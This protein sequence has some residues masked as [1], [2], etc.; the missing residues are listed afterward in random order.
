M[1]PS[2][3]MLTS[4]IS[5]PRQ[6]ASG[7]S[8]PQS[9]WRRVVR[10]VPG[11]CAPRP[12][13]RQEGI[14]RRAADGLVRVGAVEDDAALR[15]SAQES[16]EDQLARILAESEETERAEKRRRLEAQA[17]QESEEDQLAR[18]LAESAATAEAE[19]RARAE[20][21]RRADDER[22]P[23]TTA[24]FVALWRATE[25]GTGVAMTDIEAGT[26]VRT[27]N[28]AGSVS[29]A[30]QDKAQYGR[31]FFGATRTV[32]E[33]TNLKASEVF[34]D[35][36]CG[37]GNATMQMA[38]TVGCEARGIE[39]MPDR[40]IVGHEHMW[41]ALQH[42]IGERDG[43]PP[44]VGEVVLRQADL[45]DPA[46]AEFLSSAD[47]AF[48]NNYN[49]IFGARSCKHGERS[50]DEHVARVFACMKP[51]SRMVTFHPL[52]LG[53]DAE[54]VNEVRRDRGL[55]P[56][57]DASFFTKAQSTLAP[58]PTA[59]APRGEDVVSWSDGP[60]KAY[61]YTRTAQSLEKACFLCTNRK[62]VGKD[63][64]TAFVNEESLDLVTECIFCGESRRPAERD[65]GESR[66]G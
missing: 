18:I 39:L 32:A 6:A 59:W 29:G 2:R 40:H 35:I 50:L 15:Q 3:A 8:R 65:R 37:V 4:A 36:G 24:E 38:C 54:K 45:A 63:I 26:L 64:P 12:E 33:L 30:T 7:T 47:V 1:P 58:G 42:A 48:V 21:L 62:C 55:A 66:R 17:S 28:A 22:K 19:A 10:E 20:A 27:G 46:I 14:A 61:L 53:M 43:P 25:E 31:L 9:A 5:S 60:I 51:G 23:L 44:K 52:A 49:E 11:F 41:P 57:A 56:S 13:A 16:E 34:V